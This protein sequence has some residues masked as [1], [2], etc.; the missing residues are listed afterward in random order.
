MFNFLALLLQLL[1]RLQDGL[2]PDEGGGEAVRTQIRRLSLSAPVE[3]VSIPVKSVDA[4]GHVSSFTEADIEAGMHPHNAPLPPPRRDS[5]GRR[6]SSV[7]R[8]NIL[9]KRRASWEDLR[10]VAVGSVAAVEATSRVPLLMQWS[11]HGDAIHAMQV[12]DAF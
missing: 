3:S 1:S 6:R 7:G 10:H 2:G 5:M 12:C 9:K 4:E 11:A 8:E